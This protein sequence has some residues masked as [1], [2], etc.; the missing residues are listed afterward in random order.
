MVPPIKLPVLD[1]SALAINLQRL[2]DEYET[3]L[4]RILETIEAS[5]IALVLTQRIATLFSHVFVH[6]VTV[7]KSHR[8]AECVELGDDRAKI[9]AGKVVY[10][11]FSRVDDVRSVVLHARA[12]QDAQQPRDLSF[13]LFATGAWTAMCQ[14]I[15]DETGMKD[16]LSV[17]FFPMGF[18]PLDIDLLTL[19]Y[20]R[21]LH[22]CL[23]HSDHS[24]LT[25]T[26][27]ALHQLQLLYGRFPQIKYKGEMAMTVFTQLMQLQD[28]EDAAAA[29]GKQLKRRS[30]VETLILLDRRVDYASAL[31]M[32]LSYEALVDELFHIKDGFASISQRLLSGDANAADSLTPLAL[33]SADGI[34][35]QIRALSVHAV[36]GALKNC[37]NGIKNTFGEF[38][39]TSAAASASEV[40]DFVKTVP[41]LKE[42]QEMLEMHVNLLES[43]QVTTN[44]RSFKEQWQLER[45][46]MD[47]ASDR[48]VLGDVRDMIYR[49]EP[50]LKVLRVLCL[51][52]IVM[53]GLP[54]R[55]LDHIKLLL[56]R[57]YGHEVVL[58]LDNL[59]RAGL[60]TSHR[61]EFIAQTPFHTATAALQVLDYN[62]NAEN[63]KT[64]AFVT[65]GYTPISCRLVEEVLQHG[66]WAQLQA[67]LSVLPGPCA[68][69]SAA[70]PPAKGT[71]DKRGK[72]PIVMVCFVGGVTLLEVAA[73]RW[74]ASFY[75]HDIVIAAT[76]V[77]SGNSL[78]SELLEKIPPTS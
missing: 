25:D 70:Q 48:D 72:K 12:L 59:T 67:A 26:A 7:L 40:H 58:S 46:V 75:P 68:E 34:F 65:G 1:K 31:S 10:L 71:S 15:L 35:Y 45:A 22:D 11:C 53:N 49:Y 56:V 66:N 36:P 37:A 16:V 38:Q 33:N 44:S 39:R 24:A 3:A 47:E 52:S 64:M 2:R 43:I 27:I 18:V 78:L 13:Q 5:E 69:L 62:V 21:T 14:D 4:V 9:H 23:V 76:S 41:A 54:K 57:T 61:R 8:V 32:P 28:S 55:E 19:G 17:G 77:I 74:L 29:F 60:L 73:L 51:C 30:R 42:S 50:L 6:G 63:P 20:E